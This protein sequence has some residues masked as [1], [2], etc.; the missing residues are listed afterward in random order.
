MKNIK[1]IENN[2]EL[3]AGTRGASLGIEAIKLASL[4]L[5]SNFFYGKITEKVVTHNELLFAPNKYKYAKRIDG[6]ARVYQNHSAKIKKLYDGNPMIILGADHSVGGATVAGLKLANPDKTI[7]VI[8]IDAHGDLHSPYTSPSGNIH[9]MPLAIALGEDNKECAVNSID[10]ETEYYWNLLKEIGGI[11]PKIHPENLIFFGVRDTEPQED[12]LINRLNIKN[13]KVEECRQKGLENC[14]QEALTMLN[15]C[16]LIHVSF[17]VDSMD[18]SI[19]V[20]TGT[21]VPG[22]F[23]LEEAKNLITKLIQHPKINTF[24]LVEVNPLLD[25]NNKMAE[26]A[27]EIVETVY[28]IFEKK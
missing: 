28:Q 23:Y 9:G 7:G 11:C 1:I 18:T 25:T 22:G 19:S 3:G 5:N 16:D 27:F 26:V 8:W 20:G 2:S 13:F 10:K 14:V 12:E 15:D 24:E 4:K 17:D 21:P 6:I